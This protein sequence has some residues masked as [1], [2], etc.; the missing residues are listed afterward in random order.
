MHAGMAVET[1]VPAIAR[2][3]P[4]P[5]VKLFRS[6]ARSGGALTRLGRIM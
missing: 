6:A 3:H 1:N 5:S 4:A 2:H